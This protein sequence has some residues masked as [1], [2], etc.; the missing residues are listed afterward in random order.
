MFRNYI[1]Y[2]ICFLSGMMM[3]S[4]AKDGDTAKMTPTGYEFKVCSDKK[5]DVIQTGEFAFFD[6]TIRSGDSL[7]QTSHDEAVPVAVKI[8]EKNDMYGKFAPVID[9]I[10]TMS[11]GD[12]C[13]LYFPK[14]SF[15]TNNPA[16][17][18][19]ADVIT[20]EV[21]L[22]EVKNEEAYKVYQD[23]INAIK[24]VEIAAVQAREVD[25]A[26]QVQEL[27]TQYKANAIGSELQK[28]E[29]GLE[30]IIHEA[31]DPN[32]KV[33]AGDFIGVH[34]Y[35]TLKSDNTMFD[36]SFKR[37]EPYGLTV[38]RG[39][40][41]PGWDEGL[42]LLNEGSKATFFIPYELAYGKAGRAPSIP[43]ETDLIFYVEIDN[44]VNR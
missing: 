27:Y 22:K 41:I 42:Q 26:T 20:Y 4:C 13:V 5:G 24:Q 34:Y 30:Y 9:M 19:L 29:S 11:P 6:L 25:V 39:E 38:G 21:M 28:T 1:F 14:D 17:A 40:V 2:G 31:G 18:S 23:S 12:S 7:L 44:V 3:V 32:M 35:G 8:D 33:D 43:A 10:R 37:G 36:N 15:A 16:L